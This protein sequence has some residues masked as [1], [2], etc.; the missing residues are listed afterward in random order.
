MFPRGFLLLDSLV[1]IMEST[2][3][4]VITSNE[5]NGQILAG[6]WNIPFDPYGLETVKSVEVDKVGAAET[7]DDWKPTAVWCT[8]MKESFYLFIIYICQ[9]FIKLTVG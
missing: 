3:G 8:S 4:S 6:G 1:L 2:F 7:G 5:A 9:F